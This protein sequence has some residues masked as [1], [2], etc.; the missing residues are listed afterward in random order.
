M[1]RIYTSA[2][3]DHEEAE[4]YRHLVAGP[5]GACAAC[6]QPEPCRQRLL[7]AN[8]LAVSGRL[9]RRQPGVVGAGVFGLR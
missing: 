2:A 3:V 4:L 7:V 9:P 6:G 1:T 8:R 5:G